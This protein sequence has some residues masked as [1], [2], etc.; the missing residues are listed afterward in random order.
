MTVALPHWH[1]YAI[2]SLQFNEDNDLL[3]IGKESVLVHW[4]LQRQE[5]SFISRLG[6]DEVTSLSLLGSE[7]YACM[8]ANNSFKVMRLDNNKEIINRSQLNMGDHQLIESCQE[9]N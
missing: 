7:Y 3:S 8:F 5:R 9:G 6:T 1:A 4:W 2:S